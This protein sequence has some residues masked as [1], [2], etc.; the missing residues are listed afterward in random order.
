MN[1]TLARYILK[2]TAWRKVLKPLQSLV[3]I[4]VHVPKDMV[5]R[6]PDGQVAPA[7]RDCVKTNHITPAFPEGILSDMPGTSNQQKFSMRER[8]QSRG[9]RFSHKLFRLGNQKPKRIRATASAGSLQAVNLSHIVRVWLIATL[10]VVFS[11][12]INAQQSDKTSRRVFAAVL[13]IRG[14]VA[15]GNIGAY[16]VYV[17]EGNDST[18]TKVTRSN[19]ISFGLGYFERG[20]TERYYL[21]GGNGLHRST[22]GG[23][24]WRVLTS[25]TTEEILGV[26]PD[27]ADAAV[28]YLATPFGAFKTADDGSTWVRKMNG[29]K[30]W[31]VQRMIMDSRDRRTL[32]AASE[33]DVYKTT[34]AGEHW[35]PMHIG[36]PYPLALMQNPNAP[37]QFLAGFQDG[38]LRYSFDDGKTWNVATGLKDSPIYSLA[39][40]ANGKDLYAA[41][42]QTGVWRS[43][44]GGATWKQVWSSPAFEAIY[45]ICVDPQDASHILVGTVGAGLYESYD[46]GATWRHAGLMGGQV[47]QIEFYP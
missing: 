33:D 17:R 19:V 4:A 3:G 10:A 42:W 32:Y 1:Q 16:G 44:D 47:K 39:A 8:L 18:W 25:W 34:D 45:S 28:I 38:G 23:N 7:F 5:T 24:T 27:P 31:Y 26:V 11:E 40:S 6:L 43:E 36:T 20:M 12:T 22:D 2:L 13:L 29:F 30:K 35:F 14:T 41:G 37:E 9:V 46:R 21:A 15:G